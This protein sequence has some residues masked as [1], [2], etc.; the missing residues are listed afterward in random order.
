M[1]LIKYLEDRDIDSCIDFGLMAT[2]EKTST[3]EIIVPSQVKELGLKKTFNLKKAW[4]VCRG[5]AD[6]E[7]A[8]SAGRSNVD[9]DAPWTIRCPATLG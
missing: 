7:Q 3:N 8:V 6:K 5:I 9:I 4:L 1:G 2:E